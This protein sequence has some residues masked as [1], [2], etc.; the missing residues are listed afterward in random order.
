VAT[1]GSTPTTNRTVTPRDRARPDDARERTNTHESVDGPGTFEAA[2]A[3]EELR[4]EL[5]DVE[6]LAAAADA[7]LEGIPFERDHERRRALGRL[8]ALV[9][10]TAA[11]ATAALDQADE[12]L[13]RLSSKASPRRGSRA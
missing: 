2:T 8:Y 9:A 12:H 7:A 6:A 5:V 1:G 4:H 3:F 11:A 13:E 10:A